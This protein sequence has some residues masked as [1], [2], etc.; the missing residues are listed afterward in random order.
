MGPPSQFKNVNTKL[1]LFK[2]NEGPR[3]GAETEGKAIQRL[4]PPKDPSHLQTPNS[5]TIV[6][7][8]ED[9]K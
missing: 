5:F 2:E 6:D 8:D 7:A 4:P 1:F 3:R 9:A